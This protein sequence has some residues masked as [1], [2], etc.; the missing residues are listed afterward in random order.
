[1][2]A[3]TCR[4]SLFLLL[5]LHWQRMV[6]GLLAWASHPWLWRCGES[7]ESAKQERASWE[8]SDLATMGMPR[9]LVNPSSFLALQKSLML[10]AVAAELRNLEL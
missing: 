6:E 3:G 5:F 7:L 8:R 9:P 4:V 1:M 2:A 10:Q